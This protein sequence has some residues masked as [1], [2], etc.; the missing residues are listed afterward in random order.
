MQKTLHELQ[1][2]YDELESHHI[3]KAAFK[4]ALKH[5]DDAELERLHRLIE[6]YSFKRRER[7]SAD[8]LTKTFLRK[9]QIPSEEPVSSTVSMQTNLLDLGRF[10]LAYNP[11][12]GTSED[13][14][15]LR[16]ETVDLLVSC[17][18]VTPM[19]TKHEEIDDY[20]QSRWVMTIWLSRKQIGDAFEAVVHEIW[21]RG[22]FSRVSFSHDPHD[23]DKYILINAANGRLM[24]LE[25]KDKQA[26]I[27][28]V[29]E[30]CFP[31]RKQVHFTELF[32][33]F[34]DDWMRWFGYNFFGNLKL[35]Q[36]R[37]KV[38]QAIVNLEQQIR[39]NLGIANYLRMEG[40]NIVRGK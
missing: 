16:E 37:E 5:I 39:K 31:R 30:E 32:E 28:R 7:K 9:V 22:D 27:L 33:N 21:G 34:S 15:L 35:P 2:Y 8:D 6:S 20:G 12:K 3:D 1:Q 38:R 17:N 24:T 10:K 25:M 13:V 40:E 26:E 11:T 23:K 36:K 29:M 14:N 19:S 18:V 4:V